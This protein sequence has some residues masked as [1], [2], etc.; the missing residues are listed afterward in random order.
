[1]SNAFRGIRGMN[2]IMFYVN[3]KISTNRT[4]FGLIRVRSP[5]HFSHEMNRIFTLYD[6]GN[7]RTGNHESNEGLVKRLPFVTRILP[8]SLFLS[9]PK[10]FQGNQSQALLLESMDNRTHETTLYRIRF[11]DD[12]RTLQEEPPKLEWKRPSYLSDPGR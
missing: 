7:R 11:N 5:Y 8:F 12:K 4:G 1:M 3:R 9:Y 6:E 2:K 10:H